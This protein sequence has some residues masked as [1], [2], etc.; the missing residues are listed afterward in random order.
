VVSG[1]SAQTLPTVQPTRL[2]AVR[3]V[4]AAADGGAPAVPP[5]VSG[6]HPSQAQLAPSPRVLSV[7]RTQSVPG[8]AAPLRIAVARGQL[9]ATGTTISIPPEKAAVFVS[10]IHDGLLKLGDIDVTKPA[11]AKAALDLWKMPK[12]GMLVRADIT[13]GGGPLAST[14]EILSAI[15]VTPDARLLV[16]AAV[17]V[18]AGEA[19]AL[20]LDFGVVSCQAL[21][22]PTPTFIPLGP[23]AAADLKPPFATTELRVQP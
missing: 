12:P 3:L 2:T 1:S 8:A 23:A 15:D 10:A 14:A 11:G 7:F 18:A 19:G 20:K 16:A 22:N 6:T 5:A 17:H 21:A 13:G 9:L 4:G